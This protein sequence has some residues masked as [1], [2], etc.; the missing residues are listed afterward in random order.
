MSKKFVFDADKV[1]KTFTFSFPSL[2][3][4]ELVLYTQLTV[5]ESKELSAKYPDHTKTGNPD[6]E[7]FMYDSL[8][9][10]LISWNFTDKE[11]NDMPTDKLPEV[12]ERIPSGDLS[13]LMTKL[14]DI[15]KDTV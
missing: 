2:E 11:G 5:G 6:A 9:K 4:S 12:L 10:I 8:G 7:K 14:M 1:R 13:A 3:G 15:N